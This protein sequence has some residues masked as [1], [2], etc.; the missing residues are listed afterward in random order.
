VHVRVHV[1]VRACLSIVHVGVC[2][3]IQNTACGA[4]CCFDTGVLQLVSTVNIQIL[5]SAVYFV[6]HL[7]VPLH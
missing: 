6:A 3:S 7:S 2:T 4:R 5:P 1:R